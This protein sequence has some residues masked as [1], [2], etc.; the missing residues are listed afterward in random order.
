MTTTK[1]RAVGDKTPNP[2]SHSATTAA[3]NTCAKVVQRV[4]SLDNPE[5]SGSGPIVVRHF[6][7]FAPSSLDL[8]SCLRSVDRVGVPS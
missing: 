7:V 3:S 8:V 5:P 6:F 2:G 4:R 1:P